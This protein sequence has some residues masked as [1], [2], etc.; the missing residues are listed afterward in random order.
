MQL[1]IHGRYLKYA[2]SNNA[3]ETIDYK[4]PEK[5]LTEY[6]QRSFSWLRAMLEGGEL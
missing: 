3:V 1:D 6:R 2:V 5:R 4:E